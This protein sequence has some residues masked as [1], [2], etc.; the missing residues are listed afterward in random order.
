MNFKFL[1]RYVSIL[2]LIVNIFYAR[3]FSCNEIDSII[4]N[5]YD[6]GDYEIAYNMAKKN[7]DKESQSRKEWEWDLMS[8]LQSAWDS[9]RLP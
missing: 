8:E 5:R 3:G 7:K 1:T 9:S 2:F 4:A 6:S